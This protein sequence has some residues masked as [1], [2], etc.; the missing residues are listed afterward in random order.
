[1]HILLYVPDNH[2][3][4]NFLPQ[5]WPFILKERTP[6]GHRVT[7]IDGNAQR[8]TVAEIVKFVQDEGV[9]L[10]GMGFMT[11][12]ARATY[13]IATAI[14]AET[15]AKVV[16]GGP[17][18][19]G[20]PD[21]PLG[22]TGIP[23]MADAIA[24]G[25]ADDI[26]AEIVSDAERGAL[27]ESYGPDG[28]GVKP[29]LKDYRP[30][31]WE[32]VDLGLFDL[33]RF[34]PNSIRRVFDA[35]HIPF[36]KAYFIPV[37]SGRGCPYGCEFCTVT[38][39]FGKELRF[40]SNESVIAELLTLKRVAKRDRALVSVFFVDDNFAIN[41]NRL[42]SLLRDMI[43]YDA[44]VPWTGQI[45]VNL[46]DDEELVDLI[47]RSN[48]RYIFMGLES[49]DPD[50]L[51]SARKAFNKP[52]DYGRILER[53]ARHDVYAV[54]SFIV[55]MDGDRPGTA[56]RF[57]AEI[58][59]WPP[60]LPVFGLLTPYPSTPLYDKFKASGRLLRP[61][62]WLEGGAFRATFEPDGFTTEM[63]EAELRRAWARSYR[64]AA[65]ARTQRW[66]VAH[67]KGM[68]KQ[69]TSFITRLLFRGI[70]FPQSTGWQ[71]VRLLGANLPTIVSIVAR[72]LV[73]LRRRPRTAL[74]SPGAV[75]PV[76][77]VEA[78]ARELAAEGDSA[79]A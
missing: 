10:V 23:R 63:F 58:A 46:L 74:P 64:P 33:M 31:D 60:V 38:G 56:D 34:V 26:W 37:E 36:Q 13:E 47:H 17:H 45:S 18:V 50:S 75:V 16:L 79:A 44:C 65:F 51:K 53:M 7:I 40:R 48:G 59:K 35:M 70:Y 71:W 25:E 78:P 2:V 72:E 77:P 28:H 49:V 62:H 3:T 12:M 43:R 8:L 29:T 24:I 9:D 66:M 21:E 27:A 14:R 54:T 55:G 39:F 61:T 11:R 4:R 6:P 69:V 1:M 30:V 20:L 32:T 76:V 19:T 22:R 52:A 15:R 57:D 73:R 41:R 5:L 67:D 42:K 68:E